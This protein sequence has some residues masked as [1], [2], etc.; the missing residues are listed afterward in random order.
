LP[1]LEAYR[2]VLGLLDILLAPVVSPWEMVLKYRDENYG[3]LFGFDGMP[4][5]IV[6]K[7]VFYKGSP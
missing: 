1:W 4:D 2:G 7:T 6:E 5:P 3:G